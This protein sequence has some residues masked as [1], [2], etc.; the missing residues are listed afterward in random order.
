M[1][2]SPRDVMQRSQLFSAGSPVVSPSKAADSF[3]KFQPR[4]EKQGKPAIDEVKD[5]IYQPKKF[6]CKKHK[7]TEVEYCC[8][9]NETFYC[10]LCLPLHNGH[11]DAVLA[12][13]CHSIQEDVI[14]LKHSYI[15]KK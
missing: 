14:K 1:V 9:I 6:M 7:E 3:K 11:E 15:E 2:G 4:S 5:F 13:I 12:D 8:G 10:K